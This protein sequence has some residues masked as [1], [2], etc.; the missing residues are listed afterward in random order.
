VRITRLTVSDLR[1]HRGTHQ[2]EFAPGLT[3][4]RGPNEAGKSTL[5]RALELAFT[6]RVTSSSADLDGL[7]PWDG[8]DD[9]RPAIVVE[10]QHEDD[11][12]SHVGRLEKSFRRAKG[13]V[14][15][16]VDGETI[17]DPARADERL[18]EL[19]GIPSEGFFRSTASVRHQE[20]A[21]IARDEAA[22]RDRL[23]ASISGADRGTSIAKRKL[24]RAVFELTT[25][26]DKNPGRLKRAE[27]K[28]AETEEQLAAGELALVDLERDR[29][30]LATSRERRTEAEA[31]LAERRAML[32]KARIAERLQGERD[33]AKDRY[34]RFR[35]AVDVSAEIDGLEGSHP[36]SNPLPVL[37]QSVERLR[38]LDR[39]IA[40]LTARLSDEPDTAFELPREVRWRPLSRAA[41]ALVALG[42]VVAGLSFVATTAGI[43]P[44]LGP[45]PTMLGAGIV[46]IG[47]AIAVVAYWLRRSDRVDTVLRE[48]QIARRLRGRSE[49]EQ[50][51]AQSEADTAQQLMGLGLRDL[52]SAEDLLTRED[53]HVGRIQQQRARLDGL[54]GTE[55]PETLAAQRDAA[56]LGIEQKSAALEALGPIAKE[57]R[58]R[59]R[60]EVAVSESEHAL[61]SARDDE[62]NARARVEQNGVDA[63]A[64]A[65]LAEAAASGREHLAAL[66]RR[67]RVYRT[68]LTAIEEA[69][70]AT[71]QTATRYLERRMVRDLERVTGGRYRRV[72]VDDTDL[73]MEVW[74][75]ERQ[76]WVS[77]TELSQGTIDVVYLAA[78]LGLVRLVTGDRRPPLILDD[79]FVTLDDVR[80]TR[81]IELLRDLASDFQVL[82]LTTSARYDEHADKVVELR[83]PTAADVAAPEPVGVTAHG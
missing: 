56:A 3:V 9:L 6:R 46:A 77:V 80:A 69:E 35:Q 5:Q 2:F 14:R 12:G 66:Q 36:S 63:E 17:T 59:E 13:Q 38:I 65:A 28:L 79:P 47:L 67:E 51:L 54:V 43:V 37:R 8:A 53:E 74:A 75:P 42:A 25:K 29:D 30:V 55:P 1:T 16:D 33:A 73:G 39:R 60:L 27:A 48:N 34:E 52:A 76:G 26:G 58:A 41:I 18:A 15:L 44:G 49:M 32:E 21:G 19:T 72:R 83:G 62:A 4:I 68:A 82:Y 40:E 31:L 11:D 10:F 78:R 81:A 24:E 71:M 61:E 7:R 57:P 22:L 70:R 45:A 20:L 23:Q 50:E 64:V